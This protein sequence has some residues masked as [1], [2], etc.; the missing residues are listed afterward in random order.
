[1]AEPPAGVLGGRSVLKMVVSLLKTNAGVYCLKCH[2]FLFYSL[3]AR[4]LGPSSCIYI[5]S[6]RPL[7]FPLL[8]FWLREDNPHLYQSLEIKC[9]LLGL[10]CDN[11]RMGIG[12]LLFD[13]TPFNGEF[14]TGADLCFCS[15]W[16]SFFFQ[17]KAF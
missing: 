5:I 17:P 11:A 12:Q 14:I 9:T 13:F 10:Q 16:R 4:E 7:F 1:M 15:I 2:A 8:I 6:E 3:L